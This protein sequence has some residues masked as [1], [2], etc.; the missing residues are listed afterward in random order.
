MHTEI[1][2]ASTHFKKAPVAKINKMN[3][4]MSSLLQYIF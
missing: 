3:A 2:M 4:V 1:T